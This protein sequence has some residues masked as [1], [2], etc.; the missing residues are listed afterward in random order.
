MGE[1]QDILIA[2]AGIAGLTTALA[3][4]QRGL[5]VTV[6]DSF[7]KPSEVGAGLQ[8]APNASRLLAKLGVLDAL[9]GRAIAPEAIRLGNAASGEILL[10][11]PITT[12]W[13]ERM[14]APYLTAQRA[15]L[16]GVLYDAAIADPAITLKTGHRLTGGK[17]NGGRIELA[18]ETGDGERAITTGI[19]IGADGIWSRARELVRG[20]ARPRPTGRIAWRATGPATGGAAARVTAW[21]APNSHIITYPVRNMSTVNIVAI[22]SGNA[23]PQSWDQQADAKAL[24]RLIEGESTVIDPIA[25]KRADWTMWPLYRMDPSAAWH[26][27]RV[28]LIG[29]AAHGMEPFA[30]QGAAMAIEDGYAAAACLAEHTSDPGQA[31]ERFMAMRIDRIRRVARRTSLN[32]WTYHQSGPGRWARDRLMRLRSGEA[33]LRDLDWLYGYCMDG[34]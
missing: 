15:A 26:S 18:L 27:E 21:M 33:F 20:S 16:H 17:E 3:L 24:Q 14:G 9:A 28:L 25:L 19:L 31:F 29:D 10:D 30:A 7:E 5:A 2:G 11:M 4:A 23:G 6:V 34:V 13:L 22:T 32:R 12:A 1:H 8:L